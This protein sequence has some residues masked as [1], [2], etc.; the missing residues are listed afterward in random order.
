MAK[1]AR[2]YVMNGQFAWL[3][4]SLGM[5]QLAQRIR[6]VHPTSVVSVHD[7]KYG[8]NQILDDL[9]KYALWEIILIGYSLGANSVT[10]TAALTNFRIELGVCYDPSVLG[11]VRQP[12]SNLKRLLLYHNVDR[13]PE[14]HLIF[15]G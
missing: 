1:R 15:T 6:G 12:R 2:I 10:Y 9:S 7:Y 3:G 11:I 5:Y 8:P 14:G 4:S 13:E